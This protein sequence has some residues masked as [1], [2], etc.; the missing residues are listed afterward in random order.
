MKH[1]E[2]LH[3]Y[4]M[5]SGCLLLIVCI[6]TFKHA[7]ARESVPEN[8]TDIGFSGIHSLCANLCG[9]INDSKSYRQIKKNILISIIPTKIHENVSKNVSEKQF[10][11]YVL[12]LD[13]D[14]DTS[15]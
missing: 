10:R 15:I 5:F 13:T 12:Y 2:T 7:H 1:F 3:I 8:N 11:Y 9:A 14:T 6:R 4:F